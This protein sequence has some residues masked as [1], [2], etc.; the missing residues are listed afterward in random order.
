MSQHLEG[1]TRKVCVC[2]VVPHPSMLCSL[3]G[4]WLHEQSFCA[5]CPASGQQAARTTPVAMLRSFIMAEACRL[6]ACHV[7]SLADFPCNCCCSHD[8]VMRTSPVSANRCTCVCEMQGHDTGYVCLCARSWS[9]VVKPLEH[10][11]NVET[12]F[13]CPQAFLSL[14][15]HC[16]MDVSALKQ[17]FRD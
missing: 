3:F 5:R 15:F 10:L 17:T 7:E 14:D 12:Q 16:R 2:V 4:M 9:N 11:L 8:Q 6:S 1:A 13:Y